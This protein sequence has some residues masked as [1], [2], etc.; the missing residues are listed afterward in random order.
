LIDNPPA[1]LHAHTMLSN[2]QGSIRLLGTQ[3]LRYAS[4]M[5]PAAASQPG[6]STTP[7]AAAAAAAA[8]MSASITLPS[9][10]KTLDVPAQD[11]SFTM[12]AEFAPH[13]GC[14]IAWPRRTDVWRQQRQPARQAF[15][16][17]IE[18]VARFEPVTVVAHRD[19]VCASVAWRATWRCTAW[20]QALVLSLACTAVVLTAWHADRA[21]SQRAAGAV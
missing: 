5:G 15:T 4:C 20:L 8:D 14:W 13:S 18:A 6:L 11:I 3:A 1:A 9:S 10:G 16:A 21:G 17:V 7:P 2:G 12:P 19:Q